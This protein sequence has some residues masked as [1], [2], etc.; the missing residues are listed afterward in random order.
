[1]SVL[2]YRDDTQSWTG[3]ELSGAFVD[4]G[5][6]PPKLYADDEVPGT[7]PAAALLVPPPSVTNIEGWVLIWDRDTDVSVNGLPTRA[8]IR[9]LANGDQILLGSGATVFFSTETQARLQCYPGGE[10]E[11]RCPRCTKAVEPDSVGVRCP[12]CGVWYH[13]TEESPCWTYAPECAL[14]AT[15]TDLEAGYQWTPAAL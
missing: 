10:R 4:L 11:V 6:W 15:A 12:R 3:L 13:Q 1:M 5:C 9:V 7:D 2:W 8:G 14:C